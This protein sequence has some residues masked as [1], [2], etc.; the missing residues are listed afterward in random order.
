MI[1][2]GYGRIRDIKTAP[3]GAL[4]ILLNSPDRIIRITP[5]K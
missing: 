5:Q 1:L 3:D 4:Y 2:K